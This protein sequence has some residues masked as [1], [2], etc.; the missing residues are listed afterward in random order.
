[1]LIDLEALFYIQKIKNLV[2]SDFALEK[3]LK[4]VLGLFFLGKREGW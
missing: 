4:R 2:E 1:M 3:D